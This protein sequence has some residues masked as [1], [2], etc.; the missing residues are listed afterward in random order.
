MQLQQG[1][2]GGNAV[3]FAKVFPKLCPVVENPEL[4]DH[5]KGHFL[6]G[7]GL[8]RLQSVYV[9][10]LGVKLLKLATCFSFGRAEN[11]HLC[12]VG[13]ELQ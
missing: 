11:K 8:L 1:E 13:F 2:S 5:P 9:K 3:L 12:L 10:L 6:F 4:M 7:L